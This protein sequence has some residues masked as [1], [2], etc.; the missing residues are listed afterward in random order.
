VR[1]SR[2]TVFAGVQ[3]AST[4]AVVLVFFFFAWPGLE[5]SES[6]KTLVRRLEA[7]GLAADLAGAYRVPDVSLDFYLGRALARE[8]EADGLARH[9]TSE[10]GRLWVVRADEV[11][12][13]AAREPLSLVRVMTVSRRAVVRLSPG[14]PEGGRKDGS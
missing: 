6:T 8:T 12:S 11:E 4:V 2:L 7:G 13:L 10:P 1:F 14:V 9:V 5:S 3:A